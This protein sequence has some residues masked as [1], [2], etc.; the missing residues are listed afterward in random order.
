[1]TAA[2]RGHKVTL[3]DKAGEIGGQLNM[4][5]VIPPGKEEFFGL[6]EWFDTM[7]DKYGGVELRLNTQ[8]SA[9][10]MAGFD[11][12][13]VATGVLPRD[14]GG[15]EGQDREGV[16]SYVDL[17]RGKAETGKRV[18][19]IGAGGIGFDVSEYLVHEAKARPK[20]LIC[21]AKNGGAWATRKK[22]AVGWPRKGRNRM[23]PRDRSR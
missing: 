15:I 18:A 5:K 11:E 19:V 6:V 23:H 10:D 4:A 8:A 3:F 14:P 21:G 12:V 7:M 13:V 17:L 22:R 9:E 16:L 2:R 1:M 20:T